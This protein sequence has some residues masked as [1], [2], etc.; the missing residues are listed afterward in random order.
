LGF[1]TILTILS[2]DLFEQDARPGALLPEF[3]GSFANIA[4]NDVVAEHDADVVAVGEMFGQRQCV[5]D[6]A[7]TFLVGVADV[8]QAEFFSVGQQAEKIA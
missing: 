4:L 1:S 5:G 3:V 8:L 6:A 7:L 2:P